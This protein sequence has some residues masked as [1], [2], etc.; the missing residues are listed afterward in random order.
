MHIQN[1]YK[2]VVI[3][4]DPMWLIF[5]ESILFDSDY[6]IVGSA[7]NI[8]DAKSIINTLNPDLLICDIRL[9]DSLVFPLFE[10]SSFNSFPVVFMTSSIDLENLSKTQLIPQNALLLKPFHQFTLLST[11]CL[12]CIKHELTPK[13]QNKSLV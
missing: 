9:N 7:N 10:C 6:K 1:K 4:D 5:I 2:V 13:K 11:L 12:F 8:D 3:E